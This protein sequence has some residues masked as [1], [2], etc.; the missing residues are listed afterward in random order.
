MCF[1]LSIQAARPLI[2][3]YSEKGEATDTNVTL[4]AVFRAP[5]RP[6]IVNFVHFQMLKNTR[7]PYAVSEKAG[8]RL[9][10]TF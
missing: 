6:D 10:T 2:T 7:R 3:V 1:L 4:P 5:I 8:K 9:G